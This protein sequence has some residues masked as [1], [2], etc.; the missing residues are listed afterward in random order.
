MAEACFYVVK[1]GSALIQY[2]ILQYAAT[3]VLCLTYRAA[4]KTH[5]HGLW[6]AATPS[7]IC[8]F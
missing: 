5:I 2:H 6:P 7:P 4:V 8:R 3:A 1:K